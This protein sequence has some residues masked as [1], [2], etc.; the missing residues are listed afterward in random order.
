MI[1]GDFGNILT[2]STKEDPET[3]EDEA[4]RPLKTL[5]PLRTLR[6]MKTLRLLKTL[7][8]KTTFISLKIIWVDPCICF[9]VSKMIFRQF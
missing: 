9:Y 2:L 3:N 7:R 5:R 6:P 8:P 4:L 1:I